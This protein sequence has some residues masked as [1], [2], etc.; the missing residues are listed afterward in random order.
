[1]ENYCVGTLEKKNNRNKGESNKTCTTTLPPYCNT[2]IKKWSFQHYIM[3]H[4]SKFWHHCDYQKIPMPNYK[5][6]SLCAADET[7]LH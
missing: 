6:F 5:S 3:I 4:F 7:N 2:N 1:M